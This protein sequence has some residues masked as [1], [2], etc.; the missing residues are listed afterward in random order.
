MQDA[1]ARRWFQ[2]NDERVVPMLESELQNAAGTSDLADV[3]RACA[4]MLLYRK[5]GPLLSR[6]LQEEVKQAQTH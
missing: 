2:F 6:A 3:R 1:S 4:Y 5:K